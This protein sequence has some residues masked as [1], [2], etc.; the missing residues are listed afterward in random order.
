M[1]VSLTKTTYVSL[2]KYPYVERD[3]ALVVRDD[4]T[5]AAVRKEI[6]D[7]ESGIIESVSLFDVYKGKPIPP[8][9]KSLAFSI[10]FRSSDRTLTD[11]E[12]DV[13]HSNIR[14]RLKEHLGAE[15]RS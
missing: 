15:L 3:V 11:E 5:A 1:D 8:D 6:L 13:L 2:P 7:V 10:R 4:I 12:V 9:K 14:N